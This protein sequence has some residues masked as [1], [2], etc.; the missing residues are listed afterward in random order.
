[1]PVPPTFQE[2]VATITELKARELLNS[3]FLIQVVTC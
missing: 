1:M 2:L 3:I